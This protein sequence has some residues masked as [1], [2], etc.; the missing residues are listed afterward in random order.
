M[1][2]ASSSPSAATVSVH[3]LSC[4]HFT[5]PSHHFIAPSS[6]SARVTVPSLAFLIQHPNSNSTTGKKTTLL[7][8]LGLRGD[9]TAYPAAIQKHIESRRPI[10]VR[11]DVVENLA[12]G[13]MRPEDVDYIVLSHVSPVFPL[14]ICQ[15]TNFTE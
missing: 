11:P 3:A 5:L 8:D 12:R 1:A 4:G 2:Q 9:L 7:F 15:N 6:P 13:G 14:E 10:E